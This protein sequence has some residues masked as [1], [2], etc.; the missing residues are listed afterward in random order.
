MKSCL[1]QIDI[2]TTDNA[3]LSPVH[4]DDL[5]LYRSLHLLPINKKAVIS[6]LQIEGDMRRRLLDLGFLIDTEVQCLYKSPLGDPRAYL[7]RGT[8][9]AL[10]EEDAKKIIVSF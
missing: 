3:L 7:V 6:E 8:V 5:K 9:I 4:P 10:R 1:S 2:T